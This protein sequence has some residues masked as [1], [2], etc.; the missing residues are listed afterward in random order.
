M[1]ALLVIGLSSLAWMVIVGAII[2]VYKVVP[3][4]A[5]LD[6]ALALALVVVGLWLALGPSTVPTALMPSS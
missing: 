3:F 4:S 2:A 6:T 5:R 1:I